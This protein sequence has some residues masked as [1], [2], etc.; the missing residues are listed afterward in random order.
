VSRPVI[1]E[2]AISGWYGIAAA[3][4]CHE[5]TARRW[6]RHPD[7]EKRLRVAF[8]PFKRAY[9]FPSWIRAWTEANT[10]TNAAE[11]KVA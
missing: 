9:A 3:M 2:V 5:R 10:R 1:T 11:G 7:P 4:G 8:D 6:A